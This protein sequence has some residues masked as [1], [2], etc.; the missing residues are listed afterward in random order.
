VTAA[1]HFCS[2]LLF[3]LHVIPNTSGHLKQAEALLQNVL[4]FH[5]N[6]NYRNYSFMFFLSLPYLS[7][8]PITFTTMKYQ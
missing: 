5:E 3:P 4:K 8:V 7:P 1:S 2:S 6:R